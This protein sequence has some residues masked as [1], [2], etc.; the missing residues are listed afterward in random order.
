MTQVVE[1]NSLLVS[2][3]DYREGRPCLRGTGITVHTVAAH[4]KRGLTAEK[5]AEDNPGLDA[6]ALHA[7]IAYY[8]ANREQIESELEQDA[9][10]GERMAAEFPD[11]VTRENLERLQPFLR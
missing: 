2:K 5:M 1:L 6:G 3:P 7:A 8:F 4:Y 9:I 11:G 10:E